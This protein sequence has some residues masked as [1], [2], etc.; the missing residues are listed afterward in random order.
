MASIPPPAPLLE[1]GFRLDRYELLCRIG[2]GGMATVWLARTA[3]SHG[4]ER[5]VA[6]KTILPGLA[7]DDTLRTMLL[8]E[9]RIATA[10]DHP[11]VARTLEVGQ[12]WDMPY[13][14]LEYVEGES[15]EQLCR[16]L[17]E[18]SVPVPAAIVVRI[19]ADAA[20]GLHEA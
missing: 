5:L 14:V 16:S 1:P 7:S 19:V 13:L 6:I 9:A 4:E 2:Q 15:I 8:D 12:L 10:I 18:V 11:N 20:L 3:N 17:S